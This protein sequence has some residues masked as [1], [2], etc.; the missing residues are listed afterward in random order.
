MLTTRN[1]GGSV[2]LRWKGSSFFG[3][4]DLFQ[5]TLKSIAEDDTTT[6]VIILQLKNARDIDATACLALQQ[7][8]DYL[9]NSGRYLI[10]C[11]I[12]HQIWDVLSDSGMVEIIG[13]NNLF[14]FD[15]RH[16]QLSVQKAFLR[17]H[18]LVNAQT[19][20]AMELGASPQPAAG[21]ADKSPGQEEL[22]P[23]L[24]PEGI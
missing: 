20:K 1:S 10:A 11:G 7:L 5:S 16:P 13:K 15:D 21:S 2:L 17:A 19:V 18:D 22:K 6:R 23:E 4:A 8:H 12:T 9:K 3:A 14:I 24:K